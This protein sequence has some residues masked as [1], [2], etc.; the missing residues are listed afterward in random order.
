VKSPATTSTSPVRLRVFSLMEL[1]VA[2]AIIAILA[3][4]LLP[5]LSQAKSRARQAECAGN[6]R[7]WGLAFRMYADDNT[8]F[9]PRRGQGMQ[10]L[11]NII[12]PED[13]FNSLPFYFGAPSYQTMVSNNIKPVAGSKS[14]FICPAAK[15]PGAAYFLPYGMNMNLC[16]WNL[17]VA[18]KFAEVAQPDSV[19]AMADA[20]GPYASSFPSAEPYSPV[21]R[22]ASRVGLLFLAGEVQSLPGPY[23]GCGAGDPQRPDVRWLTGTASDSSANNY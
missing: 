9:L 17:P 21:A 10:A 22:H 3:A 12:R 14:M 1:L 4:V 20:P 15:D 19:V 6:L 8:D 23:V 18:T 7:Q 5:A 2:I 16:P 11:A 13:W